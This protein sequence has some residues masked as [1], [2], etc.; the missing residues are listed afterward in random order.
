MAKFE[1]CL[2]VDY[3]NWDFWWNITSYIGPGSVFFFPRY[4]PEM[5][6]A[7]SYTLGF[8]DFQ[9]ISNPFFD[10]KEARKKK[11]FRAKNENFIAGRPKIVFSVTLFLT[12]GGLW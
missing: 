12:L 3:R 9:K 10:G 1:K 7:K 6:L 4:I 8:K 11:K 2:V 5:R